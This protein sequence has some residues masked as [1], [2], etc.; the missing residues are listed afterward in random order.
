MLE[1]AE[2]PGLDPPFPGRQE[3]LGNIGVIVRELLQRVGI[4]KGSLDGLQGDIAASWLV[5]GGWRATVPGSHNKFD[6]G[7][8]RGSVITTAW[9][10]EP[11]RKECPVAPWSGSH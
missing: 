4:R 10:I 3:P 1:V 8:M 6:K 7:I 11:D 9:L 5:Q 2:Q